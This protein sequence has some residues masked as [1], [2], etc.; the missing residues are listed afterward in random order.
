MQKIVSATAMKEAMNQSINASMD[1]KD[2]MKKQEPYQPFEVAP[3]TQSHM[4]KSF[5]RDDAAAPTGPIGILN[6][7]INQ[8][9]GLNDTQSSALKSMDPDFD[10]TLFGIQQTLSKFKNKNLAQQ[11]PQRFSTFQMTPATI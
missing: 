9:V 2:T 4:L 8:R 11:T 5:A 7:S 3:R 6:Q 10:K 1:Y